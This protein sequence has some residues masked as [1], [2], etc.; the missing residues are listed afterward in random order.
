MPEVTLLSRTTVA[1]YHDHNYLLAFERVTD[2]LGPGAPAHLPRQRSWRIRAKQVVLATGAIERPLVFADNDRPGIMLS[3]AV[4]G[5]IARY[6]VVP[7]DK[8]VVFTNNDDAYR[9]AIAAKD[10][11][12]AFVTIVDVRAEAAS[13]LVAAA[14]E[15]GIVV[16]P[17][18]GIVATRG[19]RRVNEVTLAPLSDGTLATGRIEVDCD[20]I[21]MSGGWTPTVHL[22]SQSRGK[23]T[24]RDDLAAFVPGLV[25]Q[26][27][28]SAGMA[29]RHLPA[30]RRPCGGR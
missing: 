24:W 27:E 15:R 2:H 8:I 9:T 18:H 23:L 20:L 5:Y 7:G 21:A 28:A 10:A 25:V 16:Y 26:A 13:G 29:K 19:G 11:G 4:Q 17:S 12:A 30:R 6:G 1:D 22:H 14:R 3:S